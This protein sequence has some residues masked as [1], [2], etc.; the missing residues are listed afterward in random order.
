MLEVHG[1]VFGRYREDTSRDAATRSL[2]GFVTYGNANLTYNPAPVFSVY[3]RFGFELQSPRTRGRDYNTNYYQDTTGFRGAAN[4]DRYGVV[5]HDARRG[6][7]INLGRQDEALDASSTLYNQSFKVGLHTFLDGIA[8]IQRLKS[9]TVQ[10]YAFSEDQYR[11]RS[12]R[13]GL[14]ALRGTYKP[15]KA[16][17]LGLTLAHFAS[18]TDSSRAGLATTTNYGGDVVLAQVASQ[19]TLEYAKSNAKTQNDLYYIGDQYKLTSRD[20][21]TVFTYKVGKNADIGQ[22]TE[23][24]NAR[25]GTR[26]IYG[27]FFSTRIEGVLFYEAAYRL[28]GAEKTRPR[29]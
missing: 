7:T 28:A 3:V 23:Y 20:T 9:S 17:T 18:S 15:G 16:V 10:A 2:R 26:Y 12:T 13:N 14:Y 8:L 19:W 4:F 27:H 6:L 1:T 25:R 24:F 22:G 21:I 5:Y 29:A 11:T